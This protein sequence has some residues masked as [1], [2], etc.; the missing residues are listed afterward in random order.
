MNK[1]IVK[2]LNKYFFFINYKYFRK[3]ILKKLINEIIVKNT[4]QKCQIFYV[5]SNNKI[6][7]N[8]KY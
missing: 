5:I 6:Y 8:E 4:Y 7:Y 3:V 2:K 1:I